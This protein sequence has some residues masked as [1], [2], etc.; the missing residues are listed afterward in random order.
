MPRS[1]RRHTALFVVAM[2]TAMTLLAAACTD[3]TTPDCSSPEAGCSPNLEASINEAEPNDA[4]QET[5]ATDTGSPVDSGSDAR[6]DAPHDA[7]D[8]GDAHD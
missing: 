2:T 1:T 7:T 4:A 6:L 3:G 5:S 8:A